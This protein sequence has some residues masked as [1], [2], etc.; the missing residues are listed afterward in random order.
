MK[1]EMLAYINTRIA[2]HQ[3]E[4]QRLRTAD[5][6]DEAAHQQIIINMY[7]IYLSIYRALNYDLPATT[8][9]FRGI[10][11]TWEENRRTALAHE[12]GAKA[13]IEE[14][15]LNAATEMLRYAEE[16]EGRA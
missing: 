7:G 4:Q 15:K 1:E 8:E 9:R 14:I 3:Q 6:A 10:V 11:S 2:E 12:D 16:M 5:R 13:F